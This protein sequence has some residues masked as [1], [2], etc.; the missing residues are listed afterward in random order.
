MLQHDEFALRPMAE[1]DLEQVL[2]WRNS[3]R[4]RINMYTD[5]VIN[6]DEHRKWFT[7][8]SQTKQSFH[9]IFELHHNPIGVINVN[10]LDRVNGRCVWGFYLGD[11]TA[12]KGSGS[13]MGYFGLEEIF[14][15]LGFR[16]VVGEAFAFNEESI[17]F[18]RRL[19]FIE[20]GQ[21][22][23][24]VLKA[25]RYEDIICFGLLYDDWQLIKNKLGKKIFEESVLLCRS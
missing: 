11:A 5:H 3:D 24:H 12:P 10:N 8:V 4:I 16:K 20:E 1:N 18:H 17:R 2:E 19:G 22:R 14:K 7:R 21:F 13:A 15:K 9:Y 23:Q 25:G 6:M